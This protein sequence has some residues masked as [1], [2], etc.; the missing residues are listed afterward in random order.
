M[1]RD[2]DFQRLSELLASYGHETVELQRQ[3]RSLGRWSG[4]IDLSVDAFYSEAK[5]T[6]Q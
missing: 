6:W 1:S 4:K 5:G 3:L 2:D